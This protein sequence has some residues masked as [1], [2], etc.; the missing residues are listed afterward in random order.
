MI[1]RKGFSVATLAADDPRQAGQPVV[2]QSHT[3]QNAGSWPTLYRT[4]AMSAAYEARDAA[5]GAGATPATVAQT[6]AVGID[7]E[8]ITEHV[9][10]VILRRVSVERE[11]RGT[12]RWL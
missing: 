10:R 12:G 1:W 11:R 6:N 2:P 4:E 8:Q 7:L 9:T 3:V 5:G